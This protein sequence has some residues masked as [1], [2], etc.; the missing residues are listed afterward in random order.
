MSIEHKK[1]E[2]NIWKYTLI[3]VANKRIFA[4]ILSVYY[5]TIPDV[6]ASWIGTFILIG[7]LAGFVFEVPSGYLSD[8]IGHKTA[9]VISRIATLLST[10]F[11]LLAD[12]ISFLILGT[13]FLSIGSAFISGTGSAFMHETLRAL[14]RESEYTKVIGKASSIGFAVPILLTVAIPFLVSI[15]FKIP[16][17]IALVF[18]F[19]GLWAALALVRPHVPQERVDEIDVK[20]FRD[21]V[22]EGMEKIFFRYALFSGILF[23]ALWTTGIFRGPYQESLGILVI[24]FGVLHGIGRVGASLLLA[25]SGRLRDL[26]GNIHQF[27]TAQIVVYGLLYVVLALC[28][29]WWIVASAFILLNAFQWGMSKVE[30]GYLLDMVRTS[31]FKATLLSLKALIGELAT[32]VIGFSIGILVQYYGFQVGFGAL[33]ISV[34]LVLMILHIYITKRRG[35]T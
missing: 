14:G 29:T 4:A 25:Y 24:W 33:G 28:T 27:Q 1:L 19:L 6:T 10:L 5:L 3:L 21:V 20:R 30:E 13:I 9:L 31:N 18:D 8:K 17:L 11:F 32:A 2:S 7:S 16:F 35:T 26:I 34:I 12:S 15:S 22:K 23:G